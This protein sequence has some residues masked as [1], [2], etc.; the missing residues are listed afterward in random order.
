MS[1]VSTDTESFGRLPVFAPRP[2]VLSNG[3]SPGNMSP[4][5]TSNHRLSALNAGP[6]SRP[7][8]YSRS[9]STAGREQLR[10]LQREDF[11][12]YRNSDIS[13]ANRDDFL[14]A[15]GLDPS[16]AS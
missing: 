3:G 14:R 16:Q 9:V 4:M 5:W 11:L 1:N 10:G 12:P 8:S 13:V 2:T 15:G 6:H 7:Q